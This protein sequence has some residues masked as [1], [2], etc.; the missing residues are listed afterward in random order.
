ML[1]GDAFYSIANCSA[2]LEGTGALADARDKN[3]S[4]V[5]CSLDIEKAFDLLS[6]S[7]LLRKLYLDYLPPGGS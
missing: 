5:V 4:L 7:H 3:N 6:H 2:V 1:I